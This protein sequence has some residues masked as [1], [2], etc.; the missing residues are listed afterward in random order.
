MLAEAWDD[1]PRHKSKRLRCANA[2]GKGSSKDIKTNAGIERLIVFQ[3]ALNK[4]VNALYSFLM[5]FIG[6]NKIDVMLFG[7]RK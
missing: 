1:L 6:Q 5:N 7:F 4:R 3:H 2:R